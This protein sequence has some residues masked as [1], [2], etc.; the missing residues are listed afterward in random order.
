M[1][2]VESKAE[3]FPVLVELLAP[4]FWA[5]WIMA[6]LQEFIRARRVVWVPWPLRLEQRMV[7]PPISVEAA[8]VEGGLVVNDPPP[9]KRQP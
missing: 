8:A 9:P 2:V 3:V 1:P 7:Q 5:I 6:M 4:Q